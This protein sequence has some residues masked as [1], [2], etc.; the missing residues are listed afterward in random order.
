M[1]RIFTNIAVIFFALSYIACFVGCKADKPPQ[2]VDTIP[3]IIN[4]HT[5]FFKVFFCK[6]GT[7]KLNGKNYPSLTAFEVAYSEQIKSNS[8]TWITWE[9]PRSEYTDK[10]TQESHQLLDV[11]L[12]NTKPGGEF[13]LSGRSDY[14]DL[15]E[16]Q[17]MLKMN[18]DRVNNGPPLDSNSVYHP[19]TKD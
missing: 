16:E 4:K 10:T 5:P 3:R 18:M 12:K 1:K 17:K 9:E 19:P 14:S 15:V 2:V 13:R 7:I 8:V 11:I 6:D